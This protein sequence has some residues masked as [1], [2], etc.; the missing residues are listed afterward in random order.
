M[1]E[2]GAGAHIVCTV[3]SN[4][5]L[6]CSRCI[7]IAIWLDELH[8]DGG[9]SWEET[10]FRESSKYSFNQIVR[11]C[12]PHNSL[13]GSHRTVVCAWSQQ[14]LGAGEYWVTGGEILLH[15]HSQFLH[16]TDHGKSWTVYDGYVL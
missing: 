16:S 8:V 1:H 11:S 13:I 12:G 5:E 15:Q 9:H 4:S 2:T 3:R 14:W 10:L 7:D 6:V